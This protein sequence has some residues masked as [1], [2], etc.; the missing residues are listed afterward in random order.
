MPI[1]PELKHLYPADWKAISQRIR[2]ARAK[3]RCES[4]DV[5]HGW[6]RA[7]N[8]WVLD[9]MLAAIGLLGAVAAFEMKLSKIIL[10]TAHLDH[11][12]TNNDEN[13]LA[14]LCQRCHL[15]HD[16]QHHLTSRRINREKATGQGRLF[17][18]K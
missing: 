3:G 2:F 1:N 11:D 15:A 17:E 12:P 9:P 6:F 10:T 14:A 13:N 5:P 4:C 16:L 8:G 18:R 7:L